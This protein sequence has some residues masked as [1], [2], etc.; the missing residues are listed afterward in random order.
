MSAGERPAWAAQQAIALSKSISSTTRPRSNN[1]ASAVPGARRAGVIMVGS[2][3]TPQYRYGWI[4]NSGKALKTL[5]GLVAV[6][7]CR[8]DLLSSEKDVTPNSPKER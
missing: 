2:W 1:S 3:C 4:S 8:Q 6:V 5:G 7:G